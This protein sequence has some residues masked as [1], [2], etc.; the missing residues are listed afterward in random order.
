M[1]GEAPQV[2]LTSVHSLQLQIYIDYILYRV[3]K[4]LSFQIIAHFLYSTSFILKGY[5]DVSLFV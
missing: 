2:E 5:P 4:K 3:P 1:F